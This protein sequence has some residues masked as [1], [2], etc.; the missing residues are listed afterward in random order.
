[1]ILNAFERQAAAGL[2]R[3]PVRARLDPRRGPLRGDRRWCCAAGTPGEVYNIGAENERPNLDVV[4]EILR[5]TG[6]D[7]S[8]IRHVPDRPGHDRR[9]AMNS[10]KIR[11]ELG[12]RPRHDFDAGLAETVAWYRA[13]PRLVRSACAAAPLLLAARAGAGAGMRS[14]RPAG[15]R[16]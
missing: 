4:R 3:R 12:W 7:E 11:G 5:L 9:Y 15:C 2:R 6:R 14:L 13:E 16:A 10:A 1:M 8:L